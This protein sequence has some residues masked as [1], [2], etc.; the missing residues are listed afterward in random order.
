M[1]KI[2]KKLLDFKD[3]NLNLHVITALAGMKCLNSKC[4]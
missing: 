3:S 2:V 4:N 1:M